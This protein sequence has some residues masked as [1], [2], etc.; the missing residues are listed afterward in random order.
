[1]TRPDVSVVIPAY[2]A[3]RFLGEAI[4]SALSQDYDSMECIV[5]DDGS[6]D[7]TSEIAASYE[8]IRYHRIVNAGVATARNVGA[9]LANGRYLAFLDADDIWLPTKL[10]FQLAEMRCDSEAAFAYTGAHVIDEAGHFRGRIFPPAPS[11]LVMRL[12]LI[13]CQGLA[14]GSTGMIRKDVFEELGGFDVSMSTAA[15]WDFA[16]RAACR[17]R[18]AWVEKPLVLYR[19]HDRQMHSDP[20]VTKRDVMMFLKK[21]HEDPATPEVIRRN[22]SRAKANLDVSLAGRYRLKGQRKDF[23][24]HS[25][26]ALLRR[27][28]RVLAA[29]KRLTADPGAGLSP[30][31]LRRRRVPATGPHRERDP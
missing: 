24:R 4:E 27:P 7:S 12:G 18:A 21:V 30:L 14:L 19:R 1:M 8:S 25:L 15:D 20:A 29:V 5:V 17:Y 2:N 9:S 10:R 31:A 16:Y 6:E 11:E 23:F 13:E 26:K 28:D 22:I 3:G